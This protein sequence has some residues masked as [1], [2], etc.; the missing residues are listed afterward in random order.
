M[1]KLICTVLSLMI[2][3]SFTACEGGAD[4]RT[5]GTT[6]K[7]VGDVLNSAVSAIQSEDSA[8]ST[9]A[10]GDV[11]ATARAA[12]GDTSGEFDVDLT[13]LSS[14]MVYSEVYNMVTE[15]EISAS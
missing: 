13:Q 7:T 3:C 11:T 14:T 9:V 1:K 5:A 15:P 8:G 10:S 4:N 12:Q 6:Q 2:I